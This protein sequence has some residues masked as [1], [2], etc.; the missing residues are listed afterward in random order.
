MIMMISDS[1]D[2]GDAACDCKIMMREQI[3]MK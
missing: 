1:N 2:G 3:N